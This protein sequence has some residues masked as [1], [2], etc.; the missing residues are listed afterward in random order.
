MKYNLIILTLLYCFVSPDVILDVNKEGPSSVIVLTDATFE[1]HTQTSSGTSTGLYMFYHVIHIIF[2][3]L[4]PWFVKFYAPWCSHCRAMAPAWESVAKTLKG[5][6]NVADIDA[7]KNPQLSKRFNIKGYPTLVLLHK[8]KMYIYEGSNRS[9]E[10]LTAFAIADY[11]KAPV[12]PIPAPLTYFGITI[13]FIITGVH[14]AQKIYDVAFRGFL[15][16]AA[17]AYL[18]GMMLGMVISVIILTRTSPFSASS[19]VS[20][21]SNRKKD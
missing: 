17:F 9:P 8:G 13:D 21:I 15:I 10:S 11:A 6:V 18:M 14:E 3:N 4:E 7:T 20:K 1:H 16:I 2:H 5:I 19:K 12:I